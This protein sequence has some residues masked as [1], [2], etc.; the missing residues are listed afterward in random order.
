MNV[1]I[2]SGNLTDTPQIKSVKAR[3]KDIN[4]SNFTVAVKD[5]RHGGRTDFLRCEAWG[6]TADFLCRNFSKG[7]G[8][9]I[10]GASRS[11]AYDGKDGKKHYD[12]YILVDDVEFEGGGKQSE[13]KAS[14]TPKEESST[15]FTQV[16][17]EFQDEFQMMA[18]SDEDFA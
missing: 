6:S 4:V 2:I 16:T 17:D 13:N 15:G 5:F 10:M 14:E 18:A 9:K 1:V 3:G 12:N 8:I 7:K 11:E